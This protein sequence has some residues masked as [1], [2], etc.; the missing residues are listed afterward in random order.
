MNRD[1]LI[2]RF[3]HMILDVKN[4]YG[5]ADDNFIHVFFLKRGT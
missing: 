4:D 2:S 3:T 5:C 1:I